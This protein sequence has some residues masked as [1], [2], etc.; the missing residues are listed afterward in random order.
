MT[1][2]T[3]SNR[4][5][6]VNHYRANLDA[7]YRQGNS[8]LSALAKT[9]SGF[10]FQIF[11]FLSL[12]MPSGH[13]GSI[14]VKLISFIVVLAL[15]LLSNVNVS[16]NYLV[17][18][19]CAFIASIIWL[20]MGINNLGSVA[21]P[22][23][24]LR[25][26][27]ITI[28]IPMFTYIMLK[29][30]ILGPKNIYSIIIYA[31]TFIGATKLLL[32][33]YAATMHI[34]FIGLT[35][36]IGRYFDTQIM[37][38][39]IGGF[40]YRFEMPSDLAGPIAIYSL[41]LGKSFGLDRTFGKRSAHI[42]IMVI[43]FT[44]FTSYSRYIWAD[45]IAAIII[46]TPYSRIARQY[47]LAFG[48]FAGLI[49]ALDHAWIQAFISRFSSSAT[50]ISDNIRLKE[51]PILLKQFETSPII[52]HGLGFHAPHFIRDQHDKFSYELQWVALLMQIGV[53][54][55]AGIMALLTLVARPFLFLPL[56]K[57]NV[58]LL[59]MF[60]LWI[61]SGFFNPYLTSSA[62]GAIF[63]FFVAAG[64]SLRHKHSNSPNVRLRNAL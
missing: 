24:Q 7:A 18:V 54:G 47:L 58:T 49:I 19:L 15:I 61:A 60:T 6:N 46:A 55:V 37:T 34:D 2:T 35:Q 50:V 5:T 20:A 23:A 57:M 53:V 51:L 14:N 31:V 59:I 62:A 8:R 56:N 13:I 16:L 3:R 40:L 36:S 48:L 43:I 29:N 10:A 41:L 21:M 17:A 27:D 64:Y 52:G 38:M 4:L 45:L 26:I 1:L 9:L 22:V 63:S 25:A 12:V 32:L 33:L 28:L 42:L 11:L 44:A 39:P 30:E